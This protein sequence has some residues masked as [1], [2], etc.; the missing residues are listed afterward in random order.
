MS[1]AEIYNARVVSPDVVTGGHP[2]ADQLRDAADEG[3]QAVVNLAPVDH[4]SVPDE[5]GVVRAAGMSYHFIPVAW[6]APTAADFA[7]FEATMEGLDGRRVLIHCAANFRVTA[8]YSLYARKHLGWSPE[9]AAEL[10]ASIWT[11]SDHPVWETFIAE[12]DA[13]I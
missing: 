3:Y 8:F 11:G 4:R 10:R 1:T 5:A 2:T 12:V 6:D 7:A 9:R 13:T